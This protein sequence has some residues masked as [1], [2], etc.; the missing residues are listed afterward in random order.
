MECGT[1]E[2]GLYSVMPTFHSVFV[3]FNVAG[4]ILKNKQKKTSSDLVNLVCKM[5]KQETSLLWTLS[6]V[7]VLHSMF[8]LYPQQVR[9]DIY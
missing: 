2:C 8:L 1:L 9:Y 4:F 6:L 7:V 3:I 5:K